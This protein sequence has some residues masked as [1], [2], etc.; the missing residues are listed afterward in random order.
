MLHR[1]YNEDATRFVIAG[2][3]GPPRLEEAMQSALNITVGAQ[4]GT[5]GEK[6]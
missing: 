5:E 3:T 4:A 1:A 6:L 2:M